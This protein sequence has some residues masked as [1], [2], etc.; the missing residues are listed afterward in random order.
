MT[1]VY[2]E[3]RTHAPGAPRGPPATAGAPLERTTWPI[4]RIWWSSLHHHLDD[5]PRTRARARTHLELL[6]ARRRLLERLSLGALRSL[7]RDRRVDRLTDAN[8]TVVRAGVRH[9][10]RRRKGRVR[11]TH[12]R[13]VSSSGPRKPRAPSRRRRVTVVTVSTARCSNVVTD[14]VTDG[15]RD[16]RVVVDRLLGAV[17]RSPDRRTDPNPARS[18]RKKTP[19]SRTLAAGAQ[20]GSE[21]HAHPTH[22]ASHAASG[23]AS[24]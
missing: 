8:R 17:R 5:E 12:T 11:H 4:L 22:T 16:R 2:D 15:R 3:P 10:R 23:P 9:A 24:V 14:V 6:A 1:N 21:R 20:A 13:V 19:G 18:A 7:E